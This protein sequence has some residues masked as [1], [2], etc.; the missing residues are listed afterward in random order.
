VYSPRLW[1]PP[2]TGETSM[3]MTA[4][5]ELLNE[6]NRHGQ[7][8]KLFTTARVVNLFGCGLQS[9]GGDLP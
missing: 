6:L 2:S 3:D 4:K 8:L 5:N 9:I 1:V 7:A